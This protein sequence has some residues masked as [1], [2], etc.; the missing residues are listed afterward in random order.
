MSE[1]LTHERAGLPRLLRAY[2]HAVRGAA[3][4]GLRQRRLSADR[5]L[6]RARRRTGLSDFGEGDVVEPLEILV[7]SLERDAGLTPLGRRGV[8][9]TLVQ[10]L[11]KRL[12]IVDYVARQGEIVEERIRRPM[13]VVG[14]PRTGTTMLL[15]LL[16]Q[17][18][19]ARPLLG[20][21]AWA[22]IP[23]RRRR[24]SGPDP[25]IRRFALALGVLN[26]AAPSLREVHAIEVDGPDEC[27]PLLVR[28]LVTG[29]YSLA[30][31]VPRYEEWLFSRPRSA[32][33]IV[34]RFHELQLKLL[35]HQRRGERWLLKSPAHLIA[36]DALV[37]V[38][39]DACIVHTHRDVAKVF[40]STCS[41]TA[42]ARRIAS[43]RVD[44]VLLGREALTR[45]RRMTERVMRVREALPERQVCDVR[46]ADLVADPPG[47]LRRIYAHFDLP[48]PPDLE[49]RTSRWLESNRQHKHGVH[50]YSLEAFGTD[51][52]EID[53]IA[54]EYMERFDVPRED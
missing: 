13:F 50:R 46:Y 5:I 43:D 1:P 38:Y 35:Q 49:T 18:P 3:R 23:F 8:A 20:W 9:D 27:A 54:A 48:V 31:R 36:L 24:R 28:T 30:H 7:D 34:Y 17:D 51:R 10:S 39:P 11:S 25:R 45:A 19:A 52:A 33:E 22:P 53:R 44:P 14:L 40:P 37:A 41:L 4:L 26:Y 2:N 21:E 15:N 47:T 42:V 29:Y 16:A 12:R 6:A 32:F